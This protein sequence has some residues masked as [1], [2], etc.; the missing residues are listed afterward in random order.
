MV[1][2]SFIFPKH[3][4]IFV[5]LT[6]FPLSPFCNVGFCIFLGFSEQ[7]RAIFG[8]GFSNR[9]GGGFPIN[10]YGK[11]GKKSYHYNYFLRVSKNFSK[12]NMS[13]CNIKI[14]AILKIATIF[15]E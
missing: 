12:L 10:R 15:C 8:E 2:F 7:R 11:N 5:K 14:I 1:W 3:L 6:N 9:E 13:M 4:G